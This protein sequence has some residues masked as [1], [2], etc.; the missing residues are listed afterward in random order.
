MREQMIARS[1]YGVQPTI[2]TEK[3]FFSKYALN[4]YIFAV[5]GGQ[6]GPN[7]IIKQCTIYNVV[8]EVCSKVVGKHV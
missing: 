3:K 4:L 2:T 6:L 7:Q 1:F 8:S 5:R